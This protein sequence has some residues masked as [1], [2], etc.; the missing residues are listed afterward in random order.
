MERPVQARRSIRIMIRAPLIALALAA[1]L[2]AIAGPAAA[3][4]TLVESVPADGAVVPAA[5]QAVTLRFNE[6]VRPIAVRLLDGQ[7]RSLIAAEDVAAEGAM[8]RLTLPAG[9]SAGTYLVS[10]RVIS[11]D[12]HPVGGSFTFS[13]GARS[14]A[15]PAPVDAAASDPGWLA[16]AAIDRVL[17]Y[18]GLI[19]AAGGALFHR[20]VARDLGR[21]APT[22]RRRLT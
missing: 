11:L 7:G 10:Y 22:A 5:P 13:I 17:F 19:I 8:L 3:H 21:L 1:C 16:A 18:A 2:V 9:L 6:P 12:S 14:A 4:A 20:I 15:P